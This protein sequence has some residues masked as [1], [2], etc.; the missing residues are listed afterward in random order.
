MTKNFWN[1]C[2]P[3]YMYASHSGESFSLSLNR[4]MFMKVMRIEGGTS[5]CCLDVPVES[6]SN[7]RSPFVEHQEGH[8]AKQADE[9]DDL[10]H[11][12]AED[13][14]RLPKVFVVPQGEYDTKHHVDNSDDD[15]ELHLERVQEVD[16]VDRDLPDGVNPEGVRRPHVVGF[17]RGVSLR[18]LE[19]HVLVVY[20][21][22]FLLS[23]LP[24]RPEQI[25][26]F[27]ED[28]IV[29]EP[30]IDTEDAHQGD[31]VSSREEIIPDFIVRLPGHQLLF[32][33][34]APERKSKHDDPVSC[35]PK[36]HGKQEG[37]GDDGVHGRVGLPVG[38]H[39]IGVDQSL[40]SRG[41]LVGPEEGRR[42][43]SCCHF[44]QYRSNS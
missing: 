19:H 22:G 39:P 44:I 3:A 33:Q 38:S 36:H 14:D 29:D 7:K 25:H 10:G 32:L 17:I 31:Q 23:D 27:R 41:E 9:E 11:E 26:G 37:E 8:V 2:C 35:I 6:S 5:L 43:F 13:V 21:G 4:I 30:S 24:G 18:W 42:S 16:L 20:D 1:P 34:D 12:L 28:I 15:G 40:E